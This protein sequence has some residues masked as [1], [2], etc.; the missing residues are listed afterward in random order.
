MKIRINALD[1]R[2]TGLAL[3][4]QTG[5]TVVVPAV[6]HTGRLWWKKRHDGFAVQVAERRME[7]CGALGIDFYNVWATRAFRETLEAAK[8]FEATLHAA[9]VRT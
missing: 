3:G 7:H 4:Y 2:F 1:K 6:A 9:E 5:A 8:A